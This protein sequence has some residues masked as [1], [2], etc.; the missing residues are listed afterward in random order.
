MAERQVIASPTVTF[1]RDREL[2]NNNIFTGKHSYSGTDMQAIVTMPGSRSSIPDSELIELRDTLSIEEEQLGRFNLSLNNLFR[3]QTQAGEAGNLAEFKR[4]GRR[5]L[6]TAALRDR[7][8]DE[9]RVLTER[10]NKIT[11]DRIKEKQVKVLGEIQTIS[12]SI[13]REKFPVR[14]LGSVYPRGFTRGPRTIAGSLLFMVF[15]K[16]VLHELLTPDKSDIEYYNRSTTLPD[17][18]PPFDII[19]NFANE[20]G[21]ASQLVIYGIEIQDEGQVMSIDNLVLENTMRFVARDID[22]MR[23]IGT[24]EI[25]TISGADVHL[26]AYK[27]TDLLNSDFYRRIDNRYNP[28]I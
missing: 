11:R 23:L 27:S 26:G 25:R 10:L 9:I 4:L 13:H 6:T 1:T 28:F 14:S 18:I 5:I 17:Q 2:R 20:L 3:L 8:E 24:R 15:D 19:I 22:P 16:A 7:Q 12:Y 21:S